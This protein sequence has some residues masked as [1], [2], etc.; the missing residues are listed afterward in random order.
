M[1]VYFDEMMKSMYILI[2]TIF[3]SPI[4]ISINSVILFIKELQNS[5]NILGRHSI[6]NLPYI[7]L[8]PFNVT[9]N[10]KKSFNQDNGQIKEI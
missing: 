1:E 10:R 4:L 9:M 3:I 5:Y 6:V 2:N 7:F 8:V